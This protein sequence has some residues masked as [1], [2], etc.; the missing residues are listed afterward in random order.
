LRSIFSCCQGFTTDTDLADWLRRHRN[1]SIANYI[2]CRGRTVRQVREEAALREAA[3]RP[4]SLAIRNCS[5]GCRRAS[6]T[7]S[8]GSS[9][10]RRNPRGASRCLVKVPHLLSGGSAMRYIS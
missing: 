3:R 8:C 7:R 2:N 9:S 4:T 1:P 10:M 5:K 6:F